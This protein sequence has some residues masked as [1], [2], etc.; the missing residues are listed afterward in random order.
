MTA[1]RTSA[2]PLLGGPVG[3]AAPATRTD[4]GCGR[5]AVAAR[6]DSRSPLRGALLAGEECRGRKTKARDGED[7]G[8]AVRTVRAEALCRPNIFVR[9][10]GAGGP[11]E[12]VR[13]EGGSTERVG[14]IGVLLKEGLTNIDYSWQSHCS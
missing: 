6:A 5:D 12:I 13:T 14:V 10:R 4:L 9:A 2:V 7:A 8:E 3:G 11:N 1:T